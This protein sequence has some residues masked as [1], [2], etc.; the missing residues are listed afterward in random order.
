MNKMNKI[1]EG[2]AFQFKK[3][4]G[5][6]FLTDENILNGII[7]A[8]G[9]DKDT[10]VIEIGVGAGTLTKKMSEKCK[11]V[12]GYEI[13]FSLE[14]INKDVL[15]KCSNVKIFYEDF[16]KSNI[17]EELK[18]YDYQNI[19]VVAN[20]PYYI[21]TPIITKIIELSIPVD[22]VVIM[23]Q[24]EVA[25][26]FSAKPG[27][28]DYN[29]LTVFIQYYFEVKKIMNV[30]RNAFEPSPN[31]DSMVIELVRKER[32]KVKN[33]MIFFKLVRDS[34]K[35]KRKT[36]KN[37]L[38][39]YPMDVVEQILRLYGFGLSVRAEHL[40]IKIFVAIANALS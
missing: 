12:I 37:N 28:R 15:K 27:S 40:E 30:S 10:L 2:H 31:V 22:K 9:M 34:F 25:E 18:K 21:T 24:K 17:E 16:L 6:N 11:F 36:L 3:K 35:Y 7:Q 23:I 38:V 32:F 13:D 5:Q 4:Y 1:I 39:G 33:E 20:L 19:Y 26:R 8:S 29:S 14:K